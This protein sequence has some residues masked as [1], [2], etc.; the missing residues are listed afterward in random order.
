MLP[1]CVRPER[2]YPKL[3][4]IQGIRAN[5]VYK[6]SL[7]Q[8]IDFCDLDISAKGAWFYFPIG[9]CLIIN[10]VMFGLTIKAVCAVDNAMAKLGLN[11]GK[12][13]VEMER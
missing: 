4:S 7:T 2:V 9:C 6:V 11:S 1:I 10:T 13:D 5:L 3:S 12:R 8:L